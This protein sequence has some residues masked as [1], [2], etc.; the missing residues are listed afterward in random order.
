MT[1]IDQSLSLLKDLEV[2]LKYR[3]KD[4]PEPRART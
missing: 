1:H 2:K 3:N 4:L